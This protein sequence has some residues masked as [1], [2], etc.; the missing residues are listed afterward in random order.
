MSGT[1]KDYYA[2]DE[3]TYEGE[4]PREVGWYDQKLGFEIVKKTIWLK[5]NS[6]IRIMSECCRWVEEATEH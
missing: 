2:L 1:L 6:S 3:Q 5:Q 4:H